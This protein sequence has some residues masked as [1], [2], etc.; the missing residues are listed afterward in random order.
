MNKEIII[1]IEEEDEFIP[2]LKRIANMAG[3]YTITKKDLSR[4]KREFESEGYQYFNFKYFQDRLEILVISKEEIYQH[5]S[6]FD[7]K[8][9]PISAY[10]F[11]CPGIF[12]QL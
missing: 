2:V 11:L 7:Y 1:V 6:D 3:I 8:T 4:L 9:K 5:E 10:E 12:E